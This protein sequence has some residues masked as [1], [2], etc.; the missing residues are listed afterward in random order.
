MTASPLNILQKKP[1][2]PAQSLAVLGAGQEPI[3]S[4]GYI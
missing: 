2:F 3:D 4:R 1:L